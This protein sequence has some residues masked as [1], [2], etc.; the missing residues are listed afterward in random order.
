[1]YLKRLLAVSP[2]DWPRLEAASPASEARG[3]I[4][5]LAVNGREALARRCEQAARRSRLGAHV[6]MPGPVGER[7]LYRLSPRGLAFC[8]ANTEEAAIMQL[9]C[10][11]A[12]GNRARLGG[13]AGPALYDALPARLRGEVV[14]ASDVEGADVVMT[15]AEGESLLALLQAVAGR[16]GPIASVHSLSR[17]RFDAGEFWPCDFLLNEQ[18]ITTNTTA[19]GGNASLMSIG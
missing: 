13:A 9:A 19:A 12:T 14:P 8:H 10:A 2:A 1:L 5:W 7:N 4:E 15:D 11:L 6:E 3:L 18:S 16:E 17:E